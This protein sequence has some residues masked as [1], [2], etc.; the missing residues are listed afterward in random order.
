MIVLPRTGGA[1]WFSMLAIIAIAQ[2]P[3]EYQI[4]LRSIDST[5]I[6][7][8]PVDRRDTVFNG[9]RAFVDYVIKHY[10]EKPSD[11]QYISNRALLSRLKEINCDD[12][13]TRIRGML[14]TGEIVEVLIETQEFDSI[15]HKI[16]RH[17]K[18]D[19]GGTIKAIDGKD[20]YGGEFGPEWEISTF[21]I[22]VN[23]THLVIPQ[24]AYQNLFEPNICQNQSFLRQI[25]VYTSL[26]E[27]FIYVYIY[28]GDAASTYF[29]KLIFNKERFLTKIVAD[30]GALSMYGAF[31][32]NFVGY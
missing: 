28:G 1:L 8:Y 21:T 24:T 19:Y 9:N 6:P 7:C 18:D 10:L 25:E 23:G 15:N 27:Q 22:R 12:M 31:R 3:P 13:K 4:H 16:V 14:S 17:R 5:Y 20:P 2:K 11:V 29:S 32:E 26:D 30:Y